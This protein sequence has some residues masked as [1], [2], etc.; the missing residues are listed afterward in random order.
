MRRNEEGYAEKRTRV[1]NK[2]EERKSARAKGAEGKREYRPL[3]EKNQVPRA[4]AFS[5]GGFARDATR[6]PGSP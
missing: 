4:Y 2:K 5:E 1:A 6:P 3:C